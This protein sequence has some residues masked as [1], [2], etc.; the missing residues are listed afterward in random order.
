MASNITLRLR[1]QV[2]G[3]IVST[4]CDPPAGQPRPYV[5]ASLRLQVFHHHLRLH[6]PETQVP[7]ITSTSP[8]ASTPSNNLREGVV[9][10]LRTRRWTRHTDVAGSGDVSSKN[11]S[12]RE[13]DNSDHTKRQFELVTRLGYS[14][15]S[16]AACSARPLLCPVRL[17]GQNSVLCKSASELLTMWGRYPHIDT[18]PIPSYFE[19]ISTFLKFE[20]RF[21]KVQH[22]VAV[23]FSK[24]FIIVIICILFYSTRRALLNDTSHNV[25]HICVL[26]LN[27]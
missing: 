1:E 18:S 10:H 15:K 16:Y 5:S 26:E 9:W 8:Q 23:Y 22:F 3:A 17:L 20:E 6:L 25:L 21:A 13:P 14:L 11:E 4:Y 7:A 19:D 12:T 27:R 24:F 2:P